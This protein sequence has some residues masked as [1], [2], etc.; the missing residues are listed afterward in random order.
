MFGDL[1]DGTGVL[2]RTGSVREDAALQ[3]SIGIGVHKNFTVG[4]RVGRVR[5]ALACQPDRS[6]NNAYSACDTAESSD[7]KQII[8]WKWEHLSM[9]KG[10]YLFACQ[11]ESLLP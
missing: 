3:Q 9:D 5:E 11:P 6:I 2:L 7:C 1:M 8:S 10:A 4:D